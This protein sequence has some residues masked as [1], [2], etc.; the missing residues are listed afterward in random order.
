MKKSIFVLSINFFSV[1]L[2]CQ[3]SYKI[4]K[5]SINYSV[6]NKNIKYNIIKIKNIS[7]CNLI[8]WLSYDKYKDYNEYF[9]TKGSDMYLYEILTENS[10]DSYNIQVYC[11]FI[12]IVEPKTEFDIYYTIHEPYLNIYE[13][14]S[15]PN[16]FLESIYYAKKNYP[17]RIFNNKLIIIP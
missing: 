1:F 5:Y 11:N 9:R 6:N 2:F 17:Q 4:E 12:K 3:S 16:V 8:M 7:K 10:I 15:I 14:K 13:E